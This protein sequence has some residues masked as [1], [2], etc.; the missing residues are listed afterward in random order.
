VSARERDYAA[1]EATIRE[2]WRWSI[3]PLP[4]SAPEAAGMIWQ[5]FEVTPAWNPGL[6]NFPEDL[7]IRVA[8]M[9][10]F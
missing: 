9:A 10:A 6:S 7:G 4:E 8:V 3:I 2:G 5:D 1:A